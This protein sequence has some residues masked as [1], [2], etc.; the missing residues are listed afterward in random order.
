M[1][2]VQP[3]LALLML[4]MFVTARSA[5][6]KAVIVVCMLTLL[7]GNKAHA[8][9]C[10]G[11]MTIPG[12]TTPIVYPPAQPYL[13]EVTSDQLLQDAKLSSV[14]MIILY[15]KP[16]DKACAQQEVNIQ[17]AGRNWLTNVRYYRVNI[18]R[19]TDPCSQPGMTP[20]VVFVQPDQNGYPAL[21]QASSVYMDRKATFDFMSKGMQMVRSQS[22][23]ARP[24][25][26]AVQ[27]YASDIAYNVYR[28]D[29]PAVVLY[30]NS[31]SFLSLLA[32]QIFGEA[33]LKYGQ[34]AMFFKINTAQDIQD[35]DKVGKLP[36]VVI[37]VKDGDDG[38]QSVKSTYRD[39]F[40]DMKRTEDFLNTLP[41]AWRITP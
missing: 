31:D 34:R 10:C 36:S 5:I 11:N 17:D 16:G 19:D 13:M 20:C 33:S 21:L 18:S 38:T 14:P 12:T 3:I 25:G 41:P 35:G 6:A 29:C 24:V 23:V 37:Y 9:P 40:R 30:Y 2:Q 1:D 4:F 7:F 28:Y 39:G 8:Q 27:T 26:T 15:Y 32:E 22:F